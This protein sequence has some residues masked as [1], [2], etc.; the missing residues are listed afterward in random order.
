MGQNEATKNLGDDKDL[1]AN[2]KSGF[3]ERKKRLASWNMNEKH[4]SQVEVRDM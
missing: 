1:L 3:E 4:R 2:S